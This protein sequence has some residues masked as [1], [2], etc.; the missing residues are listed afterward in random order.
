MPPTIRGRSQAQVTESPSARKVSVAS[1]GDSQV[2]RSDPELRS[3]LSKNRLF[4]PSHFT[5][6]FDQFDRIVV[7]ASNP[8]F[9]IKLPPHIAGPVSEVHEL[10]HKCKDLARRTKTQRSNQCY[11]DDELEK[12]LPPRAL[13]DDLTS[14]YLQNFESAYRILHI[15]S[16]QKE[17]EQFWNDRAKVGNGGVFSILLVMAIGTCF[18]VDPIN[19]EQLRFMAQKWIYAAQSWLSD[20]N[21]K[22]RLSIGGL[23]VYCLLLLARQ[24][25]Y[26]G[27]D[28]VWISAGSL[29]RTAMHMGLHRDP[30]NYPRMSPFHA[31]IR[32]RLWATILEMAAQTSLDCG[33]PPSISFED[34]DTLAPSNIVDDEIVES[35]RG[36]TKSASEGTF[37]Q[38]SL[39]IGLLKSLQTRL[40]VTR[41][42]NHFRSNPTYEDVLNLNSQISSVLREHT[43]R[44][45]TFLNSTCSEKPTVFQRN[46]VEHLLRRFLLALHRPFSIKARK[47]PRYY[48]SRKVCLEQ[49]LIISSPHPDPDFTRLL[50]IGGGMFRE[51]MTHCALSLCLELITQVQ[52]DEANITLQRNKLQREPLQQAIRR[53]IDLSKDRL[54]LG[55]TNV[56]GLLFQSMAMGQIEAMEMGK[57]PDEAILKAAKQSIATGYDILKTRLPMDTA[58]ELHTHDEVK[59]KGG[60][61]SGNEINDG[62]GR[63]PDTEFLLDPAD[64][65]LNFEEAA[66]WLFPAF[67]DA[68]WA[69]SEWDVNQ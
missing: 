16:F 53:I 21:E 4:G 24:T 14:R 67:D 59:P 34:F 51:V 12:S 13:A 63:D 28:L 7:F 39:Q 27:S 68:P 66:S 11:L 48:F 38:T 2:Q 44:V 47:D 65:D 61:T 45:Q 54:R 3:V 52:E 10:L 40:E 1:N 26:V 58:D 9:R 18:W 55:E 36:I 64:L 6:I 23:Q 17:Y 25:N 22:K 35:G 46:L 33:M 41:M 62:E 32:R 37:T 20:P 43:V 60:E 15:P 49:A 19:E 69:P 56:K 31:E 50:A 42:I 29:M 5:N 30:V 8:D 57:S